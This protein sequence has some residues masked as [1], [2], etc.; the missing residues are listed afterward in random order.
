MARTILVP[1]KLRRAD[2]LDD[3]YRQMTVALRTVSA[4]LGPDQVW[5]GH[6]NPVTSDVDAQLQ[7]A[8]SAPA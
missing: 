1:R 5:P 6:A 3:G 4:R 2:A 8:A 7:R